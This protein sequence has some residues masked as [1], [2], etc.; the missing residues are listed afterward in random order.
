M[1][2]RKDNEP[3]GYTYQADV[4]CDVCILAHLIRQEVRGGLRIPRDHLTG[5]FV[6]R[7]TDKE[8]AWEWMQANTVKFGV[9]DIEDETTWDSGDFPKPLWEWMEDIRN[10][11]CGLCREP[12]IEQTTRGRW[13]P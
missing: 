7:F 3:V 6:L 8:T 10:D 12:L 5:L 11:H 13:I 4:Y 9:Q 1:E 2:D